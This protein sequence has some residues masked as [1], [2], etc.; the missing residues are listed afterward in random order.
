MQ[1]MQHSAPQQQHMQH[2]QYSAP[3]Q[4]HMQ[5]MQHMHLN[6]N[7]CNICTSTTTHVIGPATHLE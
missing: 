1:H 2:M 6:N 4:Q 7:I 5:H 3:Q